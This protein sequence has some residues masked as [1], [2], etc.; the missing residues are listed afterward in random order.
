[1]ENREGAKKYTSIDQLFNN[2]KYPKSFRGNQCLGPCLAKGQISI[3][4]TTLESITSKQ[5]SF[6][7]VNGFEVEDEKTGKK[8]IKYID[9]CYGNN[10][11]EI[12]R[13]SMIMN[14]LVPYLDFDVQH[15]LIIFY[16]IKSYEDGI[17]WIKVN[18]SHSVSTRERIF[19]CILNSYGSDINIIDNRTVDFF[20]LLLSDKYLQDIYERL[21]KYIYVDLL[22]GSVKI[23]QNSQSDSS[24]N[25][26]LKKEYILKKFINNE[27]V[28]R[29][30]FKYFRN[31]KKDWKDI[32]NYIKSMVEDFIVYTINTIR[33]SIEK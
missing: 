22:N 32:N 13:T 33:L 15:F 9:Q 30:L 16:N 26:K 4:P 29:F 6:C 21:K 10:N 23:K 14:I 8:E 7:A 20:Y 11:E 5:H 17:E 24:E 19:E 28:S 2:K 25:V 3:H 31:R 18:K 1:M 12:D 27:D